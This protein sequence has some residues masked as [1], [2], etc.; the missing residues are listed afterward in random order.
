MVYFLPRL[1]S[2]RPQQHSWAHGATVKL[3]QVLENCTE[4]LA[5]DDQYLEATAVGD[6]D[7]LLELAACGRRTVL[8]I[9]FE[10]G[11]DLELSDGLLVDLHALICELLP[12]GAAGESA[13]PRSMPSACAA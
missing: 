13:E 8:A 9:S 6:V 5:L 7:E 4:L 11:D 3:R 12:C 10:P 1:G 2:P